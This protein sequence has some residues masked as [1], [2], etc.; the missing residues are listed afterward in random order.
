MHYAI[1]STGSGPLGESEA[2]YGE[3]QV[4]EDVNA[5]GVCGSHPAGTVSLNMT[6]LISN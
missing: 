6:H 5:T 4:L 2:L 1:V 3:M